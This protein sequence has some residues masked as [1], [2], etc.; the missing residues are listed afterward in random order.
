MTDTPICPAEHF[1]NACAALED[2][3]EPAYEGQQPDLTP[4][5]RANLHDRVRHHVFRALIWLNTRPTQ[6]E[7]EARPSAGSDT[8][9]DYTATT[10]CEPSLLDLL[11]CSPDH[12]RLALEDLLADD[13]GI[14]SGTGP[15]LTPCFRILRTIQN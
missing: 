12:A 7:A 10:L 6:D 3:L 4:D 11:G 13:Y 8:S 9:V 15:D 14:V 2:A 5:R 1:A